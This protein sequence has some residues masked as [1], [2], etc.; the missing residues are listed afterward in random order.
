MRGPRVVS[1][2]QKKPD[3]E[4]LKKRKV[5]NKTT[6]EKAPKKT[7]ARKDANAPKR[8]P[9][10]F[11]VFMEDFRKSYKE[12]CPDNKSVSAVGKAGGEKW[13]SLSEDEKASY[14]KIA[15]QRKA[16]YGKA[17]EAY[18]KK[19]V[20]PFSYEMATVLMRSLRSLRSLRNPRNPLL[21]YTMTMAKKPALRAI[22]CI[23]LRSIW[24]FTYFGGLTSEVTV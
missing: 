19:L 1:V 13:K 18:Q 11:F 15:G 5:E 24:L 3:A 6:K 10:A 17:C 7:A 2:A 4:I 23:G 20:M 16:D 9:T 21:R 14:I 8:P 22:A 12:S